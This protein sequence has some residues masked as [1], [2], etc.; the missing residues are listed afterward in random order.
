MTYRN[1]L[2]SLKTIA[3]RLARGK[4]I[5][6]HEALDLI[7]VKLA[8]PHWNAL[9]TAWERGWRPTPESVDA[10]IESPTTPSPAVTAIPV[11]GTPF[12]EEEVLEIDGHPYSLE[13]DL[14]VVLAGRGWA[15]CV[16]QAP[17]EEPSIEVYNR[18]D[19]NPALNPDFV[20]KALAIGNVAAER[21]RERIAADWPR[22]STKP[23][24]KGRTQHPLSDG[25]GVSSRWY[26]L[27]C[28]AASSGAEMAGNMWHCPRCNATPID[29][30]GEP[31]WRGGA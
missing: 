18:S 25:G 29:I 13:G 28:D 11:L 10:L 24:A 7:A 9:T 23:D 6:H 21:M 30:F 3:K 22:R 17:S 8:Q 5:A 14:E 31:F 2:Q 16:H 20:A 26:C 27:H 1:D 15:I 4:R 12:G 19:D